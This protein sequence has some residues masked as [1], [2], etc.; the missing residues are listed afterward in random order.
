M[1]D[2]SGGFPHET[3]DMASEKV[4]IPGNELR[5]RRSTRIVQAVP[6]AVTGVDALGRSFTERTSTLIINC[7][8]CRYQSK[9]YVLKNMWVT[10]EIPHP[11][12]GQPP[13]NVRGRVAWI[14]RPRTVRQLFQVALELE[15][16]GNAWGMAF[17]PE[18][19]FTFPDPAHA[20]G[21]IAGTTHAGTSGVTISGMPGQPQGSDAGT[22]EDLAS[23]GSEAAVTLNDPELWSA[24]GTDNVRV[25]PS[26]VS[27][28]DASLQLA[29]QMARLISEA[30]QQIQAAA[31]DA[32]TNAVSA[33]RHTAF[34]QWEQKFAAARVEVVN[35][36]ERA[37]A[38]IQR[39]TAEQAKQVT[40]AAEELTEKARRELPGT[41]APQL[42]ELA[43]NVAQEASAS[44]AE[45]AAA[46]REQF[47]QHAAGKVEKVRELCEQTDAAIANLTAQ[48]E[49]VAAELQDRTDTARKF[50]DDAKQVLE[51]R[52]QA[53]RE[54]TGA[55]EEKWRALEEGR[56]AEEETARRRAAALTAQGEALQVA[57]R[58]SESRLA[59]LLEAQTNAQNATRALAQ[60]ASQAAETAATR[61]GA[62]QEEALQRHALMQAA[63]EASWRAQLEAEM[64][65]AKERWRELI[66]G[67]AQGA[68]ESAVANTIAAAREQAALQ[69]EE[70]ARG[71]HAQL[72]EEGARRLEEHI[73]GRVQERLRGELERHLAGLE[74]ALARTLRE[75]EERISRTRDAA[76]HAGTEA[77][78]RA[79]QA[80]DAV[81]HAAADAEQ[82]VAVLRAS[83]E[84]FVN[85]AVREKSERLE[86]LVWRAGEAIGRLEHF[87]ARL[88]A[89]Q[90]DSM[91]GF[92]AQLDDVLTLHRNE[93]HRRSES[94][95]GEIDGR[96]RGAFDEASRTAVTQFAEQVN[97]TVQPHVAQAQEAVQQAEEAVHRLAGGRSLL[98]AAMTLQQ[99]RIRGFADEAFADSLARFRENL[100][101]VEQVLQESAQA[102]TQRGLA[103]LDG[104]IEGLKH[105][106]IED[107]LK[108]SEW[109]EK[110]AQTQIQNATERAVEH[111][112]T[113]LRDKAG[114]VSGAFAGEVDHASR[115]FLEHTQTQMEDVL[116]DAFDRSRALFAE[117]A[118]TTTAA[119][120]DEIQRT[121]RTELAG[122]GDELQR[123]AGEMRGQIETARV[124]LALRTNAEQE[125]FLKR[126]QAGMRQAMENSVTEARKSVE[127]TF[128]P[129][130]DSVRGVTQVQQ[131]ELLGL[132]Q[133]AG[134]AAAEEHREK[135]RGISNQWMLATVA[136]LDQKARGMV[137]EIAAHAEQHLRAACDQV[138][139]GVGDSLR[140][141]MREIASGMDSKA[142]GHSA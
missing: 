4:M 45:A 20:G 90:E 118:E 138:F 1:E 36:G 65:A 12:S 48:R 80:R 108:S 68:I 141:R 126:F 19:W 21:T 102:I 63:M 136:S 58:E 17:P 33:E 95:F 96:I 82:R 137:A 121:A 29:R 133:R 71:V 49:S 6:L 37:I 70:H 38:K 72:Q 99:D 31:R 92:R 139:A 9:H 62:L 67:M 66:A 75:A 81:E 83:V 77:E 119:F 131:E 14:Q 16:P 25:F 23:T 28:T 46:Q 116:R 60:E 64:A 115:N 5:K 111:A 42:Q 40:A 97:A 41:V 91:H 86:P 55:L 8:G 129:L 59:E 54:V 57:V 93:L 79:T 124:E 122:F 98:D 142:K 35:E 32:V 105:R 101:S 103:E 51:A 3:S 84:E 56:Q 130:L 89:A 34:E 13:R 73:D 114:E 127:S 132:Y 26:P 50:I 120:T 140:E 18:D 113:L 43:R 100:G 85:T 24:L 94:L 123:T 78:Q 104:K 47:E 30:K 107:V 52:A 2:S 27:I 110:K 128:A 10:L 76:A 106:A 88:D 74:E 117:A 7:H 135:L 44:L 125:D 109:Y 39:E 15:L 134:E 11:E 112:A 22:A 61:V 53:L 69:L 87:S